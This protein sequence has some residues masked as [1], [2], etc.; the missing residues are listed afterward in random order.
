MGLVGPYGW[1]YAL[2]CTTQLDVAPISS[3]VLYTL[4]SPEPSV[5]RLL[6]LGLRLCVLQLQLASLGHLL[7]P[8][9]RGDEP[10]P[11]L[12]ASVCEN[13]HVPTPFLSGPHMLGG[14]CGALCESQ[15]AGLW[16]G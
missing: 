7:A 2:F 8:L 5:L 4:P 12:S 9:S 6:S 11:F 15:N 13:F 1:V 16:P 10:G 3:L 14:D